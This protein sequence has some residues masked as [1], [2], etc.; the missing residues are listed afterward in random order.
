MTKAR[1]SELIRLELGPTKW[2]EGDCS[3]P[4]GGGDFAVVFVH[5]FGSVRDGEKSKALAISCANRNWPFAAFD[6]RGH[7]QSSGRI[8]DVRPSQLLEDLEAVR[9]FLTGRGVERL[10]LVGSS[11]GG[12]ASA[13]FTLQHP[14]TIVGCVLIAPALHFPTARWD[15][16]TPAER[17]TWRR[18]GVVHVKNEWMDAELGY[19]I[20]EEIPQFPHELLLEA[21]STPTLIFHGMQDNVVPA[22]RSIA[23]LEK[24]KMSQIDLHLYKDGDHRLTSRRYQIAE[25]ACSFFDRLLHGNP[26]QVQLV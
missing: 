9:D 12:W 16:M 14:K 8:R 2:L 19:G 22:A 20:A 4:G 13:W 21:M 1:S 17:E 7:G 5:G 3:F 18:E 6:F 11:M 10:C 23:F 25:A 24:V 15:R 26:H